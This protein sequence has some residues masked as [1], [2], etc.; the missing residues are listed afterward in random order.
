MLLR[1]KF[2]QNKNFLSLNEALICFYYVFYN[3]DELLYNF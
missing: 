3:F 1:G 2:Q